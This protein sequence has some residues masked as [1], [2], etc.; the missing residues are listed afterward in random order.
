MRI[1]EKGRSIKERNCICEECQTMIGYFDF[2]VQSSATVNM[3][4]SFIFCP[5][6]GEIVIL[7]E[8]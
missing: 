5:C 3:F 1:I 7:I 6:C 8:K 4:R 2:E